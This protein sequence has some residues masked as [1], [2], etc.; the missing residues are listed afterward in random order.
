[1]MLRVVCT[2][3]TTDNAFD[4]DQS[5]EL[6]MLSWQTDWQTVARGGEG[7]CSAVSCSS[8]RNSA[9]PRPLKSSTSFRGRWA[10]APFIKE[11][12]TDQRII[13]NR[14]SISGQLSAC[15][16]SH[17]RRHRAYCWHRPTTFIRHPSDYTPQTCLNSLI[18]LYKY[19]APHFSVT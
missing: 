10:E 3:G 6:W 16:R 15:I 5:A 12:L 13:N 8:H 4:S 17:L 9:S 2:I 11:Q 1:M 18:V 7:G 19:S 14:R